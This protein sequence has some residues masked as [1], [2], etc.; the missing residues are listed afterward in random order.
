MVITIGREFGSGGKYIGQRLAEDLGMKLYDKEILS[1]VSEESGIELEVLEEVDEKQEQSFWYT[2]ARSMYS[3]ADSITTMSE[4]PSNEQLFIEQAKVIE[5]LSENENCIIIGRCSNLILK[6]RPDVLNVFVYSSDMD[7][8][9]NRKMK[10]DSY[11]N[12]NEALKEIQRID[13]ERA[14]Y[15]NYFSP[16]LKWGD[17]KGYDL[18]IDTSKFGV[19]AAIELIK[20]YVKIIK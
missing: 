12:A 3:S 19:E 8:K 4:I 6:E 14:A 11:E 13:A 20:E 2:F 15:Y 5:E 18:M 10:Y 16:N 7:F 9:I 1:K 17:K